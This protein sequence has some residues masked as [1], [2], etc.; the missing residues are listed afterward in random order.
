MNN[1]QH[2]WTY[3]WAR[4]AAFYVNGV[5]IELEKKPIIKDGSIVVVSHGKESYVDKVECQTEVTI[6]HR[7][8]KQQV[9]DKATKVARSLPQ[10]ASRGDLITALYDANLL[11]MPDKGEE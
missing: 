4:F 10:S 11:S 9:M 7:Y 1:Y 2:E 3:D 8:G 5:V 6:I